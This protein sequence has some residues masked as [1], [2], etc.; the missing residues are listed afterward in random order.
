MRLDIDYRAKLT[1]RYVEAKTN[2]GLRAKADNVSD[3]K[4]PQPYSGAFSIFLHEEHAGGFQSSPHRQQRIGI[5][6]KFSGFEVR[7]RVAMDPGRRGEIIQ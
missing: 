7:K 6:L 4:S 3:A 5:S 2:I 1:G